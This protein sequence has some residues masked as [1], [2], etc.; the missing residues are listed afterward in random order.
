MRSTP[1]RKRISIDNQL[2]PR[3]SER[4]LAQLR[5]GL[6]ASPKRLPSK[7]FYDESG[8]ALFEEIT[9]LPEYYPTR[10]ET[11]LLLEVADEIS[12]IT[13]AKELVELGAGAATKTRV[14]LDAMQRQGSLRLF[15]PF[16][17]SET[18]VRRVSEELAEE[19]PEL[20]IHGIV[21][22]FVH[23]LTA[24]PAGA[25]RLVVLLGS[26]IGNYSPGEAVELL[27]RLG[28]RMAAGDF[29]LLGADLIKNVEV[30]EKAYNDDSGVTA[31][32]NRNILRVVNRVTDGDFDPSLFDH[33]AVYNRQLDR[34]EMH[35]IATKAHHVR[36][37]GLDLDL[38]ISENET[39]R[40]E[41]SCKYDR[42]RIQS[43]FA[44]SGFELDRWFTDP[45]QLFALALAQKK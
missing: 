43:M 27:R 8:S 28:D 12:R 29:F 21:A 18:E 7:Y 13:G 5:R 3:R 20:R 2:D 45:D 33:A 41:I 24:I 15:V 38:E 42:S 36:L 35:L 10:A 23:H 31:E 30:V 4:D 22:D 40:T 6:L 16:D 14:L 34:I 37:A 39:L 32:F 25:P 44:A 11:A 1:I 19:Y 9:H 26:T 17:V